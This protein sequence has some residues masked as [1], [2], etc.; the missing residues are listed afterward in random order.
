MSKKNTDNQDQNTG[1]SFKN[2]N[3]DMNADENLAGTTHLNE[4]VA[5]EAE[6]EKMSSELEEQKEKYLRLYAEFDNFKRR[7]A[8]ERI[9]ITQTA[10]KEV[11]ISLL[12]VLDDCDRAE[13][14]LEGS[15]GNEDSLK[16]VQLVFNKLRNTLAA[17]GLK[18]MDCVGKD[19]DPD[20][21]EAITQI[22]A[23]SADLKGKVL[24]ELVKGYLLNDKII[25]FAKVVVG[26]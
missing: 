18:P 7:S 19:F 1:N 11:I 10:G 8:R 16:G 24:E 25:R 21:H 26:F 3:M 17:K 14:Q 13:K 15:Q 4:Q 23:P 2:M 5:E 12:D 22:P 20:K 6:L 9:E